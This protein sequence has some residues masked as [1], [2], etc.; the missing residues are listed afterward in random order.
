M[1]VEEAE[2]KELVKRKR[3]EDNLVE[4]RM[5]ALFLP[6]TTLVLIEVF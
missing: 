2:N 5:S 4:P 1:S 6:Q 3:L